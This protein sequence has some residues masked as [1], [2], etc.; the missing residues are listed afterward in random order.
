M[1]AGIADALGRRAG[2]GGLGAESA[3]DDIDPRSG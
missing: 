1:T 3:D 2:C